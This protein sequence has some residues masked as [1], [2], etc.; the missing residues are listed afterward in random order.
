MSVIQQNTNFYIPSCIKSLSIVSWVLRGLQIPL[1]VDND[2]D[3]DN[4]SGYSNGNNN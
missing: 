2:D 3:N 1:F 4:N